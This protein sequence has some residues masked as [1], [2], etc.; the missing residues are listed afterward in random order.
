VDRPDP[1]AVRLDRA[2]AGYLGPEAAV[3]RPDWLAAG[4]PDPVAAAEF[5]RRQT[6]P[7][8]R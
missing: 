3:E 7:R 8:L 6:A 2:V 5:A 4:H 1:A